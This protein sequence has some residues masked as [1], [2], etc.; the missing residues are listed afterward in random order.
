MKKIVLILF[1]F[2]SCYSFADAG[3]AYRFHLNL[4]SE[5][6]DTLNGYY[7]LYTENEFRR[8]NDF[9]EYLGKDIITLYSSI[10]TIS[11]GNLALD[12]TKTEFKK[13][14]NLSD[15]WKVSINDYLD[16]G[17]TDRIFELTDA[18]Y[19]LIKIN[20]PNSV[21]IYNEN[22]AENCSTI[23]MTWNKDTELLNHRNDISEKIK[24]FEDDFTKHNDELSNYFK[25]KKESL[26][27]KG[28]LLIF[29][30]DAL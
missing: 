15:Y 9:K 26:L 28:I 14:I 8:N 5:K 11:I 25:E 17:V 10:S 20:Q 18:E 16:F 22:Y 13:T 4:V 27:N 1:L 12:F 2:V 21:G 3:Y 6:G 30:C 23:L 29:H 19:D 7:Y 24:S